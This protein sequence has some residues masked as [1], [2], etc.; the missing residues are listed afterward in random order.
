[1]IAKEQVAL[2]RLKKVSFTSKIVCLIP[3]MKH[4]G[5]TTAGLHMVFLP[6]SNDIKDLSGEEIRDQDVE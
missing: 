3:E 1:M 5:I 6:Y 2:A 4:D